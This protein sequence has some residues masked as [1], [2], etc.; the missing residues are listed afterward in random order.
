M[1]L[2]TI[3]FF[4]IFSWTQAFS[5]SPIYVS[6]TATGANDGSSWPDAYTSLTA[7]LANSSFGDEVWVSAGTY[8]P[9]DASDLSFELPSGVKLYGGFTGTEISLMERDWEANPTILSGKIDDQTFSKIVL[10]I[11]DP[12]TSTLVDGFAIQKAI[13]YDQVPC[14]EMY[15]CHSGGVEVRFNTQGT[16]FGLSLR[17]CILR[18]NHT[19]QG[20]GMSVLGEGVSYHLLME[21]CRIEDNWAYFGSGGIHIVGG[22]ESIVIR[23]CSFISN[24]T[25]DGSGGIFIYDNELDALSI[26]LFSCSFED[27]YIDAGGGGGFGLT[28]SGALTE[29]IIDSCNFIGND[30]GLPWSIESAG[31]GGALFL[32]LTSEEYAYP[33]VVRNS[34]F[35]DNYAVFDGGA[36]KIYFNQAQI[37]NCIFIGNEAG[38]K[39]G[40]ISSKSTSFMNLTHNTFVGNKSGEGG[41]AMNMW[42]GEYFITN[43]LFHGNI[44]DP[45]DHILHLNNVQ[46]YAKNNS[47]DVADCDSVYVETGPVA[48]VFD[49]ATS[50]LFNIAPQFIDE[51]AGD[52]RLDY[53]SPLIDAGDRAI[54]EQLGIQTDIAGVA[55]IING[56]PDIGAYE[57]DDVLVN[58]LTQDLSCSGEPDGLALVAPAGG[59]PPWTV[60]WSTG[61]N[62]LSIDGL[63]PGSYWVSLTDANACTRYWEFEIGEATPIEAQFEV[64]DAWSNS[65]IDGAIDLEQISGGN[66]PYSYNWNTE[67]TTSSLHDLS[68]GEYSLTITD[69]SDCDTTLV[70]NVGIIN[71]ISVIQQKAIRLYPNPGRDRLWIESLPPGTQWQLFDAIGRLQMQGQAHENRFSVQTTELPK[72]V[73]FFRFYHSTWSSSFYANWVKM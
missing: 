73:Y 67:D 8:T 21:N 1:R 41:A 6:S 71:G 70:F 53:C 34:L 39:G 42:R 63:T 54:V 44:T 38:R 52:Y 61:A 68:P 7:G 29:L 30:V 24:Y 5:Q 47:F 32:D 33:L 45:E 48:I 37:E 40:G 28:A 13:D 11:T 35:V 62:D 36:I 56:A 15:P 19:N 3:F 10:L 46:V 65:S 23:E 22:G 26:Q 9:W 27:N 55:R 66:P 4:S 51:A 20:A 18:D 50:N 31:N 69:N 72:G 64:T 43:C 58:L 60:E 59:Q 57:N 12:D 2:T 49:C 17:N 25:L 16:G 14:S